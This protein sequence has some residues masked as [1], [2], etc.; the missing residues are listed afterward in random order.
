MLC[1]WRF[2][3]YIKDLRSPESGI[4]F[5]Y[6]GITGISHSHLT[7]DLYLLAL[8]NSARKEGSAEHAVGSA[9]T[10]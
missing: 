10:G 3:V 8:N 4:F 5:T 6:P 7:M 9:D 1:F 2:P